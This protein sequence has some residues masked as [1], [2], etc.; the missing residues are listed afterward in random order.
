[1]LVYGAIHVRSTHTVDALVKIRAK[2][3]D[4]P[5]AEFLF[6]VGLARNAAN[7]SG[8]CDGRLLQD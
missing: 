1:M 7:G 5:F 8:A 4:S 6:S 3:V 2:L